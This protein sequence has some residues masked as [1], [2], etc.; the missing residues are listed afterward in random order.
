MRHA[1]P[2]GGGP[3][4]HVHCLQVYTRYI[5][6]SR[7]SRR[8]RKKEGK[9]ISHGDSQDTRDNYHAISFLLLARLFLLG[10]TMGAGLSHYSP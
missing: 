4:I 3:D 1:R 10:V 8:K 2:A 6:A 7:F 5:K 9:R